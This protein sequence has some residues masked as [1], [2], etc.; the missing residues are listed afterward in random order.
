MYQ[1][2]FEIFGKKINQQYLLYVVQEKLVCINNIINKY[3][4]KKKLMEQKQFFNRL[5]LSLTEGAIEITDKIACCLGM[6][7]DNIFV[8]NPK[9]KHLKIVFSFKNKFAYP[10]SDHND[11][12]ILKIMH[13]QTCATYI[14]QKLIEQ[15]KFLDIQI[16]SQYQNPDGRKIKPDYL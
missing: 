3:T 15:M 11:I 2:I 14:I 13:I 16:V 8:R 9:Q 4:Q 10:Q 5:I 1:F 7:L 12:Q 6:S